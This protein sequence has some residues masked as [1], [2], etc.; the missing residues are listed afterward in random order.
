MR[1]IRFAEAGAQD[2]EEIYDY[3]AADN[4]EAADKVLSR[5]QARWRS[6]LSKPGI[7]SKRDELR[8]GMRSITEGN[9][10]IFYQATPEEIEIVRVLHASRDITRIF[11]R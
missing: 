6:L 2:I 8:N 11:G 10:V 7:G 5:L 1:R 4:I 3:I 9:Y